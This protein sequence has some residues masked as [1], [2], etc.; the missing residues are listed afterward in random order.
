MITT[1]KHTCSGSFWHMGM[2]QGHTAAIDGLISWYT[3]MQS[4]LF[5]SFEDRVPVDGDR[6]M[7]MTLLSLRAALEAVILAVLPVN[8]TGPTEDTSIDLTHL[9]LNKMAAISQTIYW[10]AFSWMKSFVFWF[11]FH[12]NLFLRAQLTIIQHWF[13]HW[14]GAK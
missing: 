1:H 11:K 6:K 5:N 3:V 8:Q 4:T 12:W 10:N 7:L 13:R 14:L 2:G 9:S